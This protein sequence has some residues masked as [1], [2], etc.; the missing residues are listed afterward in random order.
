MFLYTHV[1][2]LLIYFSISFSFY[3]TRFILPSFSQLQ[4]RS[5]L[6]FKWFYAC[7]SCFSYLTLFLSFYF[8]SFISSLLH[9]YFTLPLFLS[10]SFISLY[11][12]IGI[13][14][15]Y[16]SFSFLI[17][18]FLFLQ[19]LCFFYLRLYVFLLYSFLLF[20][21]SCSMFMNSTKRLKLTGTSPSLV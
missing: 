16:F 18:H 14:V 7:I 15:H 21:A 1:A 6:C 17:S 4:Y 5:P 11:L 13:L 9:F 20:F 19:Y 3:M 8:C 10:F 12:Y 2:Y